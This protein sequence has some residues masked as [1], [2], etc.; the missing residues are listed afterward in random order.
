M[1]AKQH[2]APPPRWTRNSALARYLNISE[3][4]L[5]RW[6]RDEKLGFPNAA[7]INGISY[8][9]LNLIDG[10]MKARVV[11]RVELAAKKSRKA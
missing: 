1:T 9:D 6:Q 10:W 3:M 2:D 4:S 7:V 5:W 8:T 11:G